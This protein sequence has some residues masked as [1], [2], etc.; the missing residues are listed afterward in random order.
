MPL[1]HFHVVKGQRNPAE[2]RG[3]LDAAHDAMLEAFKVPVRD[4]YQL[5]SEHE[6]THMVIED[7]GLDIPRTPKVV[8]LQVVSRPRGKEQIAAF[9]KLLAETLQARC[10]LAPSDLM[11]S[12]IE[13]QDEH[14]SF[15]L[16][17]AQF[18]TGELPLPGAPA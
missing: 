12:I 15:G 3:L 11:V 5:V 18:L 17:R 10:G 7:T 4:R 1:L 14:W 6:P 9:Y 16:G 2:L 8:L 13:N